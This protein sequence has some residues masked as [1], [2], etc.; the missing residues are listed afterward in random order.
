MS[1]GR[2]AY[3]VTELNKTIAEGTGFLT[4][5]DAGVNPGYTP[6]AGQINSVTI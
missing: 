4:S 3:I 1:S 6:S 2:D 5:A